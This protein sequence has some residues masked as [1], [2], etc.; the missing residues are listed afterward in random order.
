MSGFL[1][2]LAVIAMA[3]TALVLCLG[4]LNLMRGGPGNTSQKLMRMRILFQAIAVV[5]LVAVL[6][7]AR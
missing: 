5:I 6:M 2:I 7:L 1:T 3:A 4:L